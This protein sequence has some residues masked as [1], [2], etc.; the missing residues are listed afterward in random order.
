MKLFFSRGI[1]FTQS[2]LMHLGINFFSQDE[3]H[4]MVGTYPKT[5]MRVFAPKELYIQISERTQDRL[6]G[7]ILSESITRASILSSLEVLNKKGALS[8]RQSERFM[9]SVNQLDVSKF[10]SAQLSLN[11]CFNKI[12]SNLKSQNWYVQNPTI[13]FVFA[14]GPEEMINLKKE[15]QLLLGRNILQ[16]GEGSASAAN[17]FFEKTKQDSIVWPIDFIRVF[18]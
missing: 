18:Y 16:A 7:E 11:T 8:T 13:D 9:A 4:E 2:F 14:N 6:V 10:A 3:W 5:M 1:W 15:D 12:I 17:V